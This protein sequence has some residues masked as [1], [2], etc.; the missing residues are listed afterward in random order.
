M[1]GKILVICATG[2]VGVELIKIL[3]NEGNEVRAAARNP[4]IAATKFSAGVETI[5]FDYERPETF[6]KALKGIDKIFLMAR[7]G[8]NHSDLAA[9]PLIDEAKKHKIK[10]IV[11]LTAF[12]AE[13]DEYF[14][15]RK[16]ERYLEASG[17]CFTHLRPN[18]FMQIFNSGPMYLDIKTTGALHLPAGDAKLS[19]I[20]IRD[21][22]A[23]GA[24]VLKDDK[25]INKAYTLTGSESLDHFQAMEI[26]SQAAK[27]KIP[28]VP[29]NEESARKALTKAGVP[30]DVIDRWAAFYKKVREGFCTPVLNDLENIIER[31]PITFSQYA[32]D[33]ANSW[34]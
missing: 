6:P 10:H 5:E 15:L 26:I 17:I 22:A 30:Q 23:A 24:V 1:P 32:N 16:L 28:Y 25:Y 3:N 20:D 8:D 31:K 18:W 13:K 29:I 4:Q 7:P 11:N 21:I 19:F 9:A 27:K 2:K 34:N 14:M 33:Y 12:G